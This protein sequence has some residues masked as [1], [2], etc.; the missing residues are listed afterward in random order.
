[1][2]SFPRGGRAP[3]RIRRTTS[4]ASLKSGTVEYRW[5]GGGSTVLLVHGGHMRAGLAVG[6][7][8]YRKFGHSVLVPSRPGYGA[9]P[10]TTGRGSEGFADATSELCDHLGVGGVAA[11]VGVSAG[12]RTAIATAAR[13][14]KLAARLV[15]DSAVGFGDWPDPRTRRAGGVLFHPSVERATWAATHALFR[16]APSLG[17]RLLLR[18]LSTKRPREVLA[19]AGEHGRAE[20]AELF[21]LMRSG[22]GFHN[23]L[24]H[25]RPV[26]PPD[27]SVPTLVVTSRAD[28]AVPFSHAESLRHEIPGAELL[29][30]EAESHLGWFSPAYRPV[31]ERV[32]RF[33]TEPGG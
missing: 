33:L 29:V 31:A 30:S 24:R 6:E 15:L 3:S 9:T 32:R 11:V 19:A 22:S 21:T 17:F 25:T 23:D 27:V 5:E 18:D 8:V 14:P 1:M 13:H 16:V 20:L 4:L 10:L 26:T 12:S 2:R 28:A 7:A